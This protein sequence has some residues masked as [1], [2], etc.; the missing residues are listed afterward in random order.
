MRCRSVRHCS[1][2]PPAAAAAATITKCYKWTRAAREH[3]PPPSHQRT[4][5]TRP[6]RNLHTRMRRYSSAKYYYLWFVTAFSFAPAPSRC[7][8]DRAKCLKLN[9]RCVMRFH[10][11]AGLRARVRERAR[12]CAHQTSDEQKP[13]GHVNASV[14]FAVRDACRNPW[15]WCQG[16]SLS[17]SWESRTGAATASARSD[18]RSQTFRSAAA[19]AG[20]SRRTSRHHSITAHHGIAPLRCENLHIATSCCPWANKTNPSHHR[21]KLK[22]AQYTMGSLGAA[23]WS[24]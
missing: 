18:T 15:P 21:Q 19:A 6:P 11:F 4:T 20:S 12:V 23:E 13:R 5:T 24:L 7:L 16:I 3:A 14:L 2:R 9:F 22:P 8:G 17:L 1:P 10:M